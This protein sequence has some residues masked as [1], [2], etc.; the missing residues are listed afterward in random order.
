MYSPISKLKRVVKEAEK[1]FTTT[2]E[3]LFHNLLIKHR[4][5]Q[6]III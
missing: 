2:V 3:Y 4:S 5:I 6:V 1:L